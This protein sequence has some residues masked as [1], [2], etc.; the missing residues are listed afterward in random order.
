[1]DVAKL[2]E[3][4]QARAAALAASMEEGMARIE[5]AAGQLRGKLSEM[6]ERR[7]ARSKA[8]KS[9]MADTEARIAALGE[10]NSSSLHK[11]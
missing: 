7:A 6:G 2:A 4:R 1:M 3:G 10:H 8:L 5:L 9:T 11:K